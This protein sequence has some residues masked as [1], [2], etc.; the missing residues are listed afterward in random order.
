MHKKHAQLFEQFSATFQPDTIV[1]W[2]KT[3][4]I[5]TSTGDQVDEDGEPMP[6]EKLELWRRDP[7]ECVSELLGNLAFKDHLKYALE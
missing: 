5:I 6:A 3:C 1:S 4:E 2:E 7:V